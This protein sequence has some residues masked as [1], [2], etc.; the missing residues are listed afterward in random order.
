MIDALL[1]L[2]GCCPDAHSHLNLLQLLVG[3]ATMSFSGLFCYFR[4]IL[5][6]TKG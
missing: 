2:C 5:T 4:A 3:G 1:H 6:K